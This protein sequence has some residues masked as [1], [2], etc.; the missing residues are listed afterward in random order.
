MKGYHWSKYKKIGRRKSNFKMSVCLMKTKCITIKL[1]NSYLEKDFLDIS[2]NSIWFESITYHVP[3]KI[4]SFF[5]HLFS[6]GDCKYPLADVT[7]TK[8]NLVV[9]DP[10]LRTGLCG[11]LFITCCV[12]GALPTILSAIWAL[13]MSSYTLNFFGSCCR[14]I[15]RYFILPRLPNLLFLCLICPSFQIRCV[16]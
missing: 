5:K 4:L 8:P 12:A 13:M 10:S 9:S 16:S 3:Q 15:T 11:K 7:H 6:D 2:S 1:L 14:F